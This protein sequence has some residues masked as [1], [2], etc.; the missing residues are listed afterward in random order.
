ML[1]GRLKER[2]VLVGALDSKTMRVVT[3]FDVDDEGVELALEAARV[4]IGGAAKRHN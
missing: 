3:H 4:V 2:G 1:A